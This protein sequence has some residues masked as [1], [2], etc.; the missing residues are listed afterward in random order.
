MAVI[1]ITGNP[2]EVRQYAYL[3]ERI[4]SLLIREQE[5]SAASR[6]QADQKHYIVTALAK[7]GQEERAYLAECLKEYGTDFDSKKRFLILR[8]RPGFKLT[9]LSP[10]QQRIGQL[11]DQAGVMLYTFCY[12]REFWAV[13]G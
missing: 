9:N 4:T 2:D 12:P 13:L 8:I 1:G 6:S 7:G 3:A 11:F 5:I 10:A